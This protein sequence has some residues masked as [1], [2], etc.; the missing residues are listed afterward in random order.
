MSG[1][2]LKFRKAKK[3]VIFLFDFHN[4]TDIRILIADQKKRLSET[5]VGGF[6][7]RMLLES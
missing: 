1:D 3:H 4:S 6:A 5:C 2:N 7:D